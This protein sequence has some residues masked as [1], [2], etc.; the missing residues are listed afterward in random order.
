[1][2]VDAARTGLPE[3]HKM[4]IMSTGTL[5]VGKVPRQRAGS[6]RFEQVTV[7][8]P[9]Y[10]AVIS[11]KPDPELQAFL[12]PFL[13]QEAAVRSLVVVGG[14][15]SSE[16]NGG[17][18]ARWPF[19]ANSAVFHRCSNSAD[20]SLTIDQGVTLHPPDPRGRGKAG[21]NLSVLARQVEELVGNAG[22]IDLLVIPAGLLA[23]MIVPLGQDFGFHAVVTLPPS[24]FDRSGWKLQRALF[25][26]GLIG[27]GAVQVARGEAH[28]FL[29]SDAISKPRGLG[30]GSRG[31][32]AMTRLGEQ[33]RFANQL[34]QYA[35]LKMY[36][37]RHGVIATVPEWRGKHLYGFDDP[38]PT[39]PALPD[40]S[41]P[42]HVSLALKLWDVDEPPVG[43]NMQGYFQETPACWRK[44]RN[45]LRRLFQLPFPIDDA[46]NGWL[47]DVTGGGARTLIAVHVRRGD[48]RDVPADNMWLRMV[49]E[50]WY[51][52]W[53]R[54][55]WPTLR[56]PL[57]FVA[58]DEPDVILPAFREFEAVSP[59]FG[60]AAQLLPKFLRD[61][62]ILRRADYLAICNSS[63]SRMAAILA[64]RAQKCFLPSFQTKRFVPYEAWLDRDFWA[65]FANGHG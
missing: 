57:L 16:K 49:P 14:D 46:I 7:P 61:F 42:G 8:E 36:A 15:W 56:D 48:Y 30:A 63:F 32:I 22:G 28:C 54:T 41:F 33:G 39:G 27:I 58:T 13:D 47:A 31:S 26:H 43:V 35:F 21:Q 23:K 45:F 50:E 1:M 6:S 11:T 9:I 62:E 53:L 55:I 4:R 5:F 64:H 44:H 25:D 65:R 19:D 2:T 3:E 37:L 60:G 29:Q 20:G 52:A 18:G 10:A 24:D 17:N 59:T 51:L 12:R 34:F 40:L 38:P